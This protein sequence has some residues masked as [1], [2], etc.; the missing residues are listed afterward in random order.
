MYQD[1]ELEFPDWIATVKGDA[2]SKGVSEQVL[3]W[4]LHD[5]TISV[6]SVTHR[7]TEP[8]KILTVDAYLKR[9]TCNLIFQIGFRQ[10]STNVIKGALNMDVDQTRM[11]SSEF[12]CRLI[13]FI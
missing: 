11:S 5:V 13:N 4:A 2:A 3:E 7:K 8:E 6:D 12:F 1:T 10:I 9:F